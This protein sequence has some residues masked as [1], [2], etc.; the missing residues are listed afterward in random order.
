[1]SNYINGITN[2]VAGI[3][4]TTAYP[5]Q[6]RLLPAE[7]IGYPRKSTATERAAKSIEDQSEEIIDI[8]TQFGIPL[9]SDDIWAEA[10]GHGGDEFWQGGGGTGLDGDTYRQERYRPALTKI[11]NAI[12]GGRVKAVI[13]WSQD[14]LWRDVEICDAIIKFFL[15]YNV[16]LYDRNGRVDIETPEGRT[17]VRNNAIAAA[18]YREISQKRSPV[19]IKKSAAKGVVVTD[20]NTLGFRSCGRYSRKV[21]HIPEEQEVV[22]RIYNLFYYGE[23]GSGPRTVRQ[24]IKLLM[25][26]QFKWT[27]DLH[28]KRGKKRN[29]STKDLIYDWQVRRVLQDARYIGK[30][31]QYGDLWDCPAYL[32]DGTEPVVDPALWHAVQQKVAGTKRIGG[33]GQHLRAMTGVLRCGQCFQGLQASHTTTTN[34]SGEVKRTVYWKTVRTE[35]WC[36]C[37]HELPHLRETT[38]DEYIDTV[39]APL[40]L[41][42]LRERA[43]TAQADPARAERARLE[44]ELTEAERRCKVELPKLALQLLGNPNLASVLSGVEQQLHDQIR[45]LKTKLAENGKRLASLDTVIAEKGL[46]DIT[47]LP[48]AERRDVVRAVIRWAAVIPSN[49]PRECVPGY[50]PKTRTR[51]ASH[52]GWLVFLTAWGTY[53]T[54]VI[55]REFRKEVTDHRQLI[56]RPALPDETL[57]TVMD[58]PDPHGFAAGMKRAYDGRKYDYNP[59]EVLPGYS[60]RKQPTIAEFDVSGLLMEFGGGNAV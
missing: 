23:E 9:G 48:Q 5:N 24:I 31:K 37:T 2:L 56:L 60:S 12:I 35:A 22:R 8:A 33:A 49:K 14:R 15:R 40:L 54:A 46:T 18:H 47:S 25:A 13:V 41:G 4:P 43:L 27:P 38:V 21:K 7:A 17:A 32:V 36:W 29:E 42:E 52:A 16:A 53:H 50:S 58:F 28:D 57:G 19:G 39:L 1:M 44:N 45:E 10:P 3:S 51:P 30:Q 34:K 6:V 59:D 26:E 11:M 20:A 55:E